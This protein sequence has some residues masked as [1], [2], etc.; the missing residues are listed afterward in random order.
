MTTR[1]LL[2]AFATCSGIAQAQVP[3]SLRR[4]LAS[5]RHDSA[6]F[7]LLLGM[8]GAS[9]ESAP[10][11]AYAYCLRA[12]AIV[13]NTGRASDPGEVQGWLAYLDEQRGHIESAQ[14]RYRISLAEA[15]RLKDT[16]GISTVLNNM[17]AIHADLGQLDSAM[18]A[19]QRSLAIR[20]DR[21]DTL[22]IANSLNNIG[23]LLGEQGKLAEA[24]EHLSESLRI[25]ELS[26]IHILIHGANTC[27]QPRG[28]VYLCPVPLTAL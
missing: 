28:Q 20:H 25:Y 9:L 8:A 13:A 22:G 7:D 26:L 27:A 12:E 17:A 23:Y 10:D 14:R 16:K 15:E 18:I 19:H 1:S 4:A 6:R 21:K 24:M 3:D 5:A 11:S 2:I